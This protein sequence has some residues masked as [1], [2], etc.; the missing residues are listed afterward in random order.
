MD[1][2]GAG[3]IVVKQLPEIEEHLRAFKTQVDE[4]VSVAMQMVCTEETLAA[5]KAERAELKKQFNALEDQRKEV[6]KQVLAPYEAFE[7]VYAECVANAFKEADAVLKSRID[8]V[9]NG[10]KS[11]KEEEIRAYFS[12]YCEALSI[13]FVPFEAA[14]PVINR[15]VSNKKYKEQCKEFIDRVAADLKMIETQEYRDEIRAEYKRCLNAAE[16][17]TEVVNRHKAIEDEKL[18]AEAERE[19]AEARA[20]AAEKV[21]KFL[22]AVEDEAFAPPV[23][24]P[25]QAPEAIYQVTFTVRGTKEKIKALKEFM[26]N[27]GYDYE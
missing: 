14:V 5:V 1:E 4:R 16:A 23:T 13:D 11:Q 20:Q 21:E 8:E 3:L 17:V 10:L 22:A 19:T 15:S 7:A 2:N 24:E 26:I 18:K 12:E 27:G 9:E 25:E 6:K